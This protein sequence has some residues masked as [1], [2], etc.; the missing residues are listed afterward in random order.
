MSDICVSWGE[1]GTFGIGLEMEGITS[2][3][4]GYFLEHRFNYHTIF[5]SVNIDGITSYFDQVPA[6]I[7]F[8]P[9]EVVIQ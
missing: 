5:P 4:R 2:L 8:F 7:T 9:L 6:S 1:R 3:A